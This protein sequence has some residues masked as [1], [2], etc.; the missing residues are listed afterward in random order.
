MRIAAAVLSI[1]VVVSGPIAA[2]AYENFIPLGHNYSPD[3]P[4]LPAFN[5]NRDRLNAQLDIYETE[6]YVEE[7]EKRSFNSYLRRF[8]SEQESQGGDYSLDY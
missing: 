1:I 8:S 5:S 7:R 6:R 3:D 4:S 2:S